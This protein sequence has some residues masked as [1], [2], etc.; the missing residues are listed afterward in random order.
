V[1]HATRLSDKTN[2]ALKCIPKAW[3][4]RDEFQREVDVLQKLSSTIGGPHPHICRMYDI[5]EG[6][7]A[8]WMA[9]ELIEGGEL[10][11]H[12][13]EEGAYS[14]GKAAVFMRQF[15][16]A[17][18][19]VHKAGVVH[20]D[21]KP[22]NLLLSS[23]D[24]EEAEL[25]L[26][27]FGCATILDN[28]GSSGDDE[29]AAPH[30]TLAY[31]PPEKLMHDSPPSFQSDVWAAGCILYI[32]LTGS[33]PFDKTGSSTDEEI[34]ARVKSIGTSEDR[35]SELAFSDGRSANLSPSVT[36]LLWYML[37]PDPTKRTTSER[38]RH[39]RWVQGLTASWNVLD[40][41][42]A[43]L[44]R[45]WQKEFRGNMLKRF[46]SAVTEEQLKSVFTQ[47]DE[48]GNGNIELEELAKVL[49]E[50]GAPVKH[51]ESIFDAINLDNDKG[52][53]FDEFRSVMKNE[54]PVEIC[55]KKFRNIIAKELQTDDKNQRSEPLRAAARR[56][57]NSMDLD[58]N[59]SLDCHEL[60]LVLRK[61]GVEEKEISLLVA[62]VDLN[63]DGFLTFD[64]FSKV[65]SLS[66][67]V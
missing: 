35:L 31:D 7:D 53:S 30:S 3:T 47:I 5:Y 32:I 39:N 67:T 10:F 34:S 59:G 23:W 27:D 6:E 51:I 41:I 56:L 15:A 14:E 16:E 24:N 65:L 25:K 20:G 9:M 38:V 55:Q 66:K 64:E 4:L 1:Y 12:L 49:R 57:F 62:S 52:I 58:Q 19:F 60:R 46:G 11:E 40:G 36:T 22:E 61:L 21:L 2:V 8:Y 37:H 13:I 43:R 45:F 48:D 54:L 44:E 63:Q 33:H 26:V 28:Y 29:Q 50:S 42:D 17:L 18:S